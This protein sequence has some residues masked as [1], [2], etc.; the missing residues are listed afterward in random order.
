MSLQPVSFSKRQAPQP[1]L[2]PRYKPGR[3]SETFWREEE[4]AVL[5]AHYPSHGLATCL[6]KLPRRSRSAIY[7]RARHL[8]LKSNK[9]A[10]R[11]RKRHAPDPE[12]DA[13][14]REAWPSLIA[15]GAVQRFADSIGID[16]WVVSKRA[17][18]L[19]LSKDYRR[20]EPTWTAAE[21]A[22]MARVPLNTPDIAARIFKDHGFKRSAT[23]I[24]VRAK[25]IGLSRR[26]SDILSA[27]SA[28]RILG[29]DGKWITARCIDGSLEAEKRGTARLVQQGGDTWTIRPEALKRYVIDSL[30]EIDIRKVD[31][32]AFVALLTDPPAE[33]LLEAAE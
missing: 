31:K 15:K 9:Q 24:V 11:P 33:P 10:D 17:A 27:T 7:M 13:K 18:A 6:E 25:R 30:E 21:D 22:L 32:F 28:A 8:G 16:R 12:L 1:R 20:K 23:A 5:V 14:I 4:D 26:R 19:G 2:S 3:H 29:V